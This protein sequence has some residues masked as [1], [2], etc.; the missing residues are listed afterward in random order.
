MFI[1]ILPYLSL[2]VGYHKSKKS[3]HNGS[4]VFHV[5]CHSPRAFWP[6]IARRSRFGDTKTKISTNGQAAAQTR[7]A[8]PKKPRIELISLNACNAA[9]AACQASRPTCR[10]RPRTDLSRLILTQFSIL[11]SVGMDYGLF[12]YLHTH[13]IGFSLE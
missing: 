9:G 3:P 7:A 2:S 5:P 13:S 10:S 12:C 4:C 1:G 8:S 6:K 11:L